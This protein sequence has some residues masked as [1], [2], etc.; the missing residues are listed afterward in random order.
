M[1]GRRDTLADVLWHLA[2]DKIPWL[3]S[4]EGEDEPDL[5]R[6]DDAVGLRRKHNEV[7]SRWL[8]MTR[9]VERRGA[10]GDRVVDALC[11]PPESFLLSQIV[12]HVL[13][14]S[15]HRRQLARWMLAQSGVD[16]D[17]L[18]PDPIRRHRSISVRLP[19]RVIATTQPQLSADIAPRT[20]TRSCGS[21]GS[22][23]KRTGR[24]AP[25]HSS[26][27]LACRLWGRPHTH[28]SSSMNLPGF[29]RYRLSYSPV[30]I[31]NRR[32]NTSASSPARPPISVRRWRRRPAVVTCG[33][34][35]AVDSPRSSL[36]SQ[37]STKCSSRSLPSRSVP[38]SRCSAVHSISHC[39]SA[40]ATKISSSPG[41]TSSGLCA[42]HD[43]R[44]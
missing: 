41:T 25:L 39:R 8:A 7:A 17:H 13:T 26:R 40:P 12:A 23:S 31:S 33:S 6:A 44:S 11:E 10:W 43:A 15:A 32:T 42:S 9:D 4:I 29:R 30:V 38:A 2:L 24:A 16:V 18:D 27:T 34:W 5:G 14:F 22:S 20:R 37:C 35:A 21:S 28:G 19:G 3:A 36:R 1:V